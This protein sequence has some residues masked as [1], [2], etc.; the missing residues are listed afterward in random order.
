MGRNDPVFWGPV[1]DGYVTVLVSQNDVLCMEYMLWCTYLNLAIF[2]GEKPLK[3]QKHSF[4][5]IRTVALFSL[6][7]NAWFPLSVSFCSVDCPEK[8]L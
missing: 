8:N 6:Y 4:W 5:I 7:A 3:N 2:S 1:A